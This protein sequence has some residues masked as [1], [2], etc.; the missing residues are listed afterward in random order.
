MF[1]GIVEE[2]DE[3]AE[4]VESSVGAGDGDAEAGWSQGPWP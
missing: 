3:V 4:I 2:D 1:V